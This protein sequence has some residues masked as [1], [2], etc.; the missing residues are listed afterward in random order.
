[1]GYEECESDDEGWGDSDDDMPDK[2]FV[3][4]KNEWEPPG[5][6]EEVAAK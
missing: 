2:H 3:A 6:D 5:G 4:T 1:M